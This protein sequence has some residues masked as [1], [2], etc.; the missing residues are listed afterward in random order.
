MYMI[1]TVKNVLIIIIIMNESVSQM[2]RYFSALEGQF[3]AS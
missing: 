2:E 1:P 3:V